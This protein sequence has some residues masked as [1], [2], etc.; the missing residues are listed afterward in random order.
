MSFS[1][2]LPT[3]LGLFL[4]AGS[5][6]AQNQLTITT[7]AFPQGTVGQAYSF[8]LSAS[9]GTAP[10]TWSWFGSQL[11]PG[12]FLKPNGSVTGTPSTPGTYTFTLAVVD[13]RTAS[14]SRIFSLTVTGQTGR[15]ALSTTALSAGFVG[16]NYNDTLQA[17]G[18]T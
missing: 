17:S 9:G 5:V 16:Q 8:T 6:S 18:G 11:P 12:L 13:A 7:T 1:R 15:L 3:A 2:L 14:A 4:A 10:Y